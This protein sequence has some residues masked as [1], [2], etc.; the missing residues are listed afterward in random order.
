M[1]PGPDDIY[2]MS[3]K[4]L[5]IRLAAFSRGS[6][7]RSNT[8]VVLND[9]AAADLAAYQAEPVRQWLG[10]ISEASEEGSEHPSDKIDWEDNETEEM[11][12]MMKQKG[13]F[14]YSNGSD[15]D[16]LYDGDTA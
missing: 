9:Q 3:G 15:D 7:S 14:A 5:D 4:S 16:D 2:S 1:E 8:P 11:W 10:T 6:R 12:S 13:E